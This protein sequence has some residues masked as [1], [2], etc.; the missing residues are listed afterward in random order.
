MSTKD[1]SSQSPT[2][3]T[4]SPT[5]GVLRAST[6]IKK[7]ELWCPGPHL[8][9]DELSLIQSIRDAITCY[10][11]SIH[12]L[13]R[14]DRKD[15]DVYCTIFVNHRRAGELKIQTDVYPIFESMLKVIGFEITDTAY[16]I[17][18]TYYRFERGVTRARKLHKS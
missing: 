9:N 15:D 5:T 8:S 10:G 6:L 11:S 13:L 7:D 16:N 3:T 2:S 12:L 18:D 1:P 17:K 14:I 4:E